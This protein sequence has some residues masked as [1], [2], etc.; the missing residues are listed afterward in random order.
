MIFVKMHG[1]GNDFV[2]LDHRVGGA[3]IDVALAKVMADRRFGVGCD[4]LIVLLPPKNPTADVLMTIYNA[5]GSLSGMCGN[6]A[7][8][9]IGLIG[10]AQIIETS[11]GLYIGRLEQN[12]QASIN[13]GLPKRDWQSIP[14]SAAMDTDHVVIP[15]L[16]IPPGIAVNVGN[17]HIVFF[18]D[19]VAAVDLES[20]GPNIEHHPLFPERINVEFVQVISPDHL[21]MRVW[22]RGAGIT[23]A[24]GTGATA[25]FIAARVKRVC[26]AQATI[27]MPGGSL[28]LSEDAINKEIIQT[29]EWTHVFK[30]EWTAS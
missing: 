17:P 21:L 3:P 30:G 14:M 10:K 23:Q 2:V 28:I 5:D 1:L 26:A 29:G 19:D 24:C 4:Q 15:G 11:G 9:V 27:E 7:R 13:M 25:S 20:I 8:C 18:V 22:E 12:G 16:D 6:A